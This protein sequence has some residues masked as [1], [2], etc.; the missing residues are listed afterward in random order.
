MEL[1]IKEVMKERGVKA[2]YLA[3][4]M[5]VTRA[6]IS[7]ISN[8][9]LTLSLRQLQTVADLLGVPVV[10]LIEKQKEPDVFY[11]PHCGKPLKAIQSSD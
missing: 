6:Y 5:G 3:E 10:S 4:Q 11:C 7:G 2:S 9:K 8:G 1:R